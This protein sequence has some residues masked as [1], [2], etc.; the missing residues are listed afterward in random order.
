MSNQNAEIARLNEQL[1]SAT[2][3]IEKGRKVVAECLELTEA[4]KNAKSK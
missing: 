3:A 2:T 4:I 1:K